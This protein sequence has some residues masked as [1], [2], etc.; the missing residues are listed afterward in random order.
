MNI[1]SIFF[2][3]I[4]SFILSFFVAIFSKAGFLISLLRGLIVALFFGGLFF[5][6]SKLFEKFLDLSS[7]SQDDGTENIS[8]QVGNKIDITIYD[9]ELQDEDVSPRFTLTGENQMLD[10]SDL[11]NVNNSS[12]ETNNKNSHTISERNSE[13]LNNQKL[14]DINE[15][16]L[17]QQG[18]SSNRE[19]ILDS[20]FSEETKNASQNEFK[21]V[22]LANTSANNQLS[23][24]EEFPNIEDTLNSN[25]G[26]AQPLQ[27]QEVDSFPDVGN[28]SGIDTVTDSDFASFGKAP[29]RL[30]ET[31]FPDGSMAESKDS[32]LMADAIRTILKKQ[33]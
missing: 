8:S 7:D 6:I 25:L 21:P 19:Q 24:L 33:E 12:T 9:E 13:D 15:S 16:A 22:S 20:S 17:L 2:T 18:S 5:G 23:E 14:S 26:T 3:S 29:S 27:D 4:V 1:K 11:L 32:T 31:V 10:K 28:A 30:S